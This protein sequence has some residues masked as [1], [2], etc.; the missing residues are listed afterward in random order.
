MSDPTLKRSSVT[1][2]YT[3]SDGY[4]SAVNYSNRGQMGRQPPPELPLLDAI[5][6]LSRLCALFGFGEQAAQRVA[7][8]RERVDA[9]RTERG[10]ACG[11]AG[12]QLTGRAG[13]PAAANPSLILAAARA[14]HSPP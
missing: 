3:A 13:G 4:R 5:E 11:V 10:N 6:E 1:I 2:N 14:T 12:D 7:Q 9:W 8:A